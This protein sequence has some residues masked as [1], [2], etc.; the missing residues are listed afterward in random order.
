MEITFEIDGATATYSRNWLTGRA[1]LT[2]AGQTFPLQNPWNPATHFSLQ[3]TRMWRVDVPNHR[4][5][6]E[7]VRPLLFAGF[8]A[9]VYRIWVNDRIVADKTGR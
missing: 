4:V 7:K 2:L 6:I 1:V 8:R 5:L 3:R 9:S